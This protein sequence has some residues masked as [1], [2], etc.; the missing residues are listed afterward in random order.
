M[1]YGP[2]KD[3]QWCTGFGNFRLRFVAQYCN[4]NIMVDTH[5]VVVRS[6]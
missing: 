1:I 5:R 4:V 2:V 6:N 3:K